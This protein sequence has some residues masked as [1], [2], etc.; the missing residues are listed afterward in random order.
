[1]DAEPKRT[2]SSAKRVAKSLEAHI[3]IAVIF[4]RP[5]LYIGGYRYSIC[6]QSRSAKMGT[7]EC[8]GNAVDLARGGGESCSGSL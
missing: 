6:I 3:L 5:D 4:W 7:A 1:M 8:T 2:K